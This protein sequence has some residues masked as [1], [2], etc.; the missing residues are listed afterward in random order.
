MASASSS[1]SY[2][3][4]DYAFSDDER[5]PVIY[6]RLG[7]LSSSSRPPPPSNIPKSPEEIEALHKKWD[8]YTRVDQ[9]ADLT[10]TLFPH[11][12]VTVHNMEELE[13]LRKIKKD[14]TTIFLSD[15]G[16][17]GDIPGYGK[18]FSV[19]SLILRDRMPWD[20]KKSNERA[21]IVTYNS[22][23]KVLSRVR[24]TR[25]RANL[26][27]VSPTLVE[28]WKEYFGFVKPGVLQIKEVTHAKDIE[29]ID[30]DQ[31]DVILC[32]S[33]R[34]NELVGH[35]GNHVVWKRFIFDEAGSTHIT[36]M[37]TVHAGFV[38]FVTATYDQLMRCVG[39]G[40]HY[41][42]NFFANINY[43]ILPYFVIR[44]EAEFVRHSF[45]MPDVHHIRHVCL[46][47]RVL[48][49]LSNF[50]DYET[51]LMIGAGDI[52]G[53][54]SRLGGGLTSESN[55]F[56]I[57]TKRQKEKLAQAKFSF[58][59]W[60]NRANAREMEHWDKKVKEIEKTI[61][62][63]EEK[64][65]NVLSEDCTICYSTISDPVLLPCCQN[66][67][68]GGCIM[69]WFETT[70]TCP[71][72]RSI[73]PIKEIVYIKSGKSS[74]DE[75]EE[76]KEDVKTP[77]SK[78][79][80][81]MEILS[82]NE[83]KKFLIF[84]MFDESFSIIRRELEE[85]KMDYV[86]ISGSKATRDAKLKR[87]KEGRVNIVFLN[88]RFN[89]AGINLEMATDIILYHEMPSSI[90]EQVIGRAL[91]IGRKGDVTVHHLVF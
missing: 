36:G 25:V 2:S 81:V 65:K 79:K 58:E 68:C 4:Q 88:S 53:A 73:V 37:R 45:K 64:Y 21:D 33:S 63:L 12:R 83:N 75:K 57:V 14:D 3:Y 59:F 1:L 42:K 48:N 41:M 39:N 85:H 44:N 54:I 86:E 78:P 91:R 18:S 60:T 72:C 32:S 35:V 40:Q 56:E 66:I 74:G 62:E 10:I 46:N 80:T 49:V 27:V 8:S 16:I 38:W 77:L 19:V 82:G 69:K 6:S 76:K 61:T 22:C 52:R 47:P 50:I 13:R 70:K 55:L 89:G 9:P 15:F 71:M 29:N 34:Y 31:W 17:L 51:R 87:F 5:E 11:Q 28:Q 7:S 84:S 23:L 24:K 26:L 30:P 90:E 20:I 43:D 67:F